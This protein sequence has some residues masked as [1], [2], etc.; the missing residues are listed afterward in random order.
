MTREIRT[1]QTLPIVTVLALYWYT[2]IINVIN[3][4]CLVCLFNFFIMIILTQY[5]LSFLCTFLSE[6]IV[7]QIF[8]TKTWRNGSKGKKIHNLVW[9]TLVPTCRCNTK[10][11]PK[12][13][14]KSTFNS[15]A[16][17]TYGRVHTVNSENIIYE[18][19]F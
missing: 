10:N 13:I 8:T 3:K 19:T 2:C 12:F 4:R 18:K 14:S 15:E 16:Q 9:Q 7:L 5:I 17:H 11:I 6:I 1:S